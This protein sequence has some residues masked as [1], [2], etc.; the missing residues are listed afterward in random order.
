[1]RWPLFG[2]DWNRKLILM[3]TVHVAYVDMMLQRVSKRSKCEEY[4]A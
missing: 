1:M 3:I 4:Y 2:N